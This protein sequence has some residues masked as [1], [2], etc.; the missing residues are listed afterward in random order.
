MHNHSL[1][2]QKCIVVAN[3]GRNKI[4]ANHKIEYSYGVRS[5]AFGALIRYFY[6]TLNMNMYGIA[7]VKCTRSTAN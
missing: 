4:N 5:L 6:E 3:S 7:I 2:M 1:N